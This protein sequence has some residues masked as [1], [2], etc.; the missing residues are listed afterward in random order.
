MQYCKCFIQTLSIQF[1]YLY[2]YTQ[3]CTHIH[4]VE[5]IPLSSCCPHLYLI[6]VL[7]SYR[8]ITKWVPYSTE[9]QKDYLDVPLFWWNQRKICFKVESVCHN[10]RRKIVCLYIWFKLFYNKSVKVFLSPNSYKCPSWESMFNMNI[11]T[12]IAILYIYTLHTKSLR[13]L[14][15]W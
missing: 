3:R 8:Q 9:T 12:L 2:L 13:T 6:V 10:E 11:F 4:T 5:N 14:W 7:P 15:I 1:G